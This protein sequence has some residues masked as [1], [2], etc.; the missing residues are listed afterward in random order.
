MSLDNLGV[1]IIGLS[2]LTYAQ[3]PRVTEVNETAHPAAFCDINERLASQR[4]APFGSGVYTDYRRILDGADVDV[5]F[6]ALPH[7]LHHEVAEAALERN[8]RVMMEKPLTIRA[9]DG[10]ELIELS[11]QKGL[12]FMPAENTRFA[13]A[14]IELEKLPGKT[15]GGNPAITL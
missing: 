12:T 15:T 9:A 2:P 7:H 14:Y 10:L 11:R 6:I 4:D 1:G 5:V 13:K 3:L 8:K